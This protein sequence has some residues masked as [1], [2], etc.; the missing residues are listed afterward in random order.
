M[1]FIHIHNLRVLKERAVE[2]QEQDNQG[3]NRVTRNTVIGPK[4]TEYPHC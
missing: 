4:E 2:T 1:N 3:G